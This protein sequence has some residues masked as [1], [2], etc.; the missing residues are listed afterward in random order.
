MVKSYLKGI[1]PC[2]FW[3]VLFSVPVTHGAPH[4]TFSWWS[5]YVILSYGFCFPRAYRIMKRFSR[6]DK[7]PQIQRPRGNA[8]EEALRD[9]ASY[10]NSGRFG[11]ARVGDAGGKESWL[12]SWGTDFVLRLFVIIVAPVIVAVDA[13]W[14]RK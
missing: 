5:V 12:T 13:M 4:L 1:V 9:G 7:G 11:T 8:E 3:F 6:K 14:Q 10:A 2:L